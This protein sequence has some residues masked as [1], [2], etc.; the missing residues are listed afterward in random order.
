MAGLNW[1]LQKTYLYPF[2]CLSAFGLSPVICDEILACMSWT[3]HGQSEAELIHFGIHACGLC[4]YVAQVAS[5]QVRAMKTI[6]SGSS[7]CSRAMRRDLGTCFEFCGWVELWQLPAQIDAICQRFLASDNLPA[8]EA[9]FI[10]PSFLKFS[11]DLASGG[12]GVRTNR[13]S[14]MTARAQ[15]NLYNPEYWKNRDQSLPK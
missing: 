4:A 2:A 3:F 7:L 13:T 5:A 12:E 15:G 9:S 11:E 14:S 8:P 6:L 10:A 1:T